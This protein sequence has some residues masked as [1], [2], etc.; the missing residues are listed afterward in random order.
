MTTEQT[1]LFPEPARTDKQPAEHR[2]FVLDDQDGPVFAD[3]GAALVLDSFHTLDAVR[4]D[5]GDESEWLFDALTDQIYAPYEWP[6]TDEPQA[7]SLHLRAL[8]EAAR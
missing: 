5:Y 1:S 7:V 8:A 3:T 4:A 6:D 2:W